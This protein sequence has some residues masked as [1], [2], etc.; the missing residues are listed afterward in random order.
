MTDMKIPVKTLKN[1][2]SLPVLGLGTWEMGGKTTR[3]PKNNDAADIAAIQ[4]AIRLG[5]THIDTA[6]M[7]AQGH[8]EE[9]VGAAIKDFNRAD[10]CLVTK[11]YP[12]HVAYDDVMRVSKRSLERLGTDYIDLYLIHGPS[13]EVPIEE[14]MQALNELIDKKMVRYIGVSNF[15][16]ERLKSAQQHSRYPIVTNQVHYNLQVREC[17][18]KRL[19]DYCQKN[20]V[21]LTAYRPIQKGMLV[22]N[23]IPIIDNMCKKYHKTPIQIALSWL[24]SQKNV[25]AISKMGNV[26]HMKENL[27]SIGWKLNAR[28]IERLRREFPGQKDVSEVATLS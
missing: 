27:G 16:V 12:N 25:V 3:D 14:T 26:N 24:V 6:E 22:N 9:L 11:V 1:G 2:F 18:K 28:D 8:T 21:L 15:S 5:V 10:L 7:Y 4:T 13:K 19:L 20:D 17:E 23:Q